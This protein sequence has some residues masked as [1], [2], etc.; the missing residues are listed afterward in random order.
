MSHF[1]TQQRSCDSRPLSY[2]AVKRT[3]SEV[4]DIQGT[5]SCVEIFNRKRII[6]TETMQ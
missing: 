4:G 3:D 6:V 5:F 2:W 1:V